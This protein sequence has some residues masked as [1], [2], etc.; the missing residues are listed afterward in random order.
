MRFISTIVFVSICI[1]MNLFSQDATV[2]PTEAQGQQVVGGTTLKTCINYSNVATKKPIC[3]PC[4][5]CTSENGSSASES[6]SNTI[7]G[8]D[9]GGVIASQSMIDFKF[10]HIH[11]A[12]DYNSLTALSGCAPCGADSSSKQNHL[13]SLVLGRYHRFRDITEQSSFGPGIFSNY[14]MT[15]TISPEGAGNRIR[16]FDPQYYYTIVYQD[17]L[18]G[19]TKDGVLF[20]NLRT[21]D[22]ARITN[23]AE[24]FDATNVLTSDLTLVKSVV[25]TSHSGRKFIFEVI[26]MAGGALA[27]RLTQI[28][29]RNG[30]SVVL[31]YKTWTQPEIDASHTLQ[32]QI[33]TITDA[34]GRV[35]SFNYEATQVSGQWVVSSIVLPNTQTIAY[36]YAGGF[37]TQIAHPDGTHSTFGY[38]TEP[39]SQCTVVS[40]NDASASSTHRRKKVYLTN[41]FSEQAWNGLPSV[42]NSA[43]LLVRMVVNGASEVSYFNLFNPAFPYEWINYIEGKVQYVYDGRQFKYYQDGWS[44]NSAGGWNA[45]SGTR[46]SS[47][48]EDNWGNIQNHFKNTPTWVRDDKGVTINLQ[49]NSRNFVTQKS[50]ADGSTE[51]F[52]YNDFMQI[53]RYKDRDNRV[54]KNT[55]DT[56][57]NLTKT[58]VGIL[59]TGGAD[60]NQAEYAT[61][62]KSYFSAGHA[63]QFLLESSTDANGN[64]TN[65]EYNANHFLV[66]VIEPAD[67]IGGMRAERVTAIDAY[68]RVA[69]QADA[70]GRTTSYFYDQKDRVNKIQYSDSS[71]EEMIYGSDADNNQNLI[72]ASKDRNGNLTQHEYDLH[73]RCTKVTVGAATMNAG[74]IS[75]VAD[76]TVK[77]ETTKSYKYGT[78]HHI[79]KLVHGGEQTDMLYDYKNREIQTTQYPN[80]TTTLVSKKLYVNNL[81]VQSTDAYN[82]KTFYAYRTSDANNIRVVRET[83][84]NAVSDH[85]T[86]ATLVRSM[87]ANASFVIRDEIKNNSGQTVQAIDPRGIVQASVYDSRQRQ[88][89]VVE[90]FGT[91]DAAKTTYQFD[92][93]SNLELVFHPRNFDN[94]DPEFGKCT[95]MMTYTG[96]NLLKTKTEGVNS[97]VSATCFYAYYLDRKEKTYTDFNGNIWTTIWHICCGRLEAKVDP[98]GNGTLYDVDYFG[99]VVHTSSGS[100]LP[101]DQS[102]YV[103]N[104]QPITA[105]NDVTTRFDERN[106]PTHTTVWLTPIGAITNKGRPALGNGQIPI[107]G[108]DGVPASQGLTTRYR[109]DDNLTDN[110]G[111]DAEYASKLV[112]LNIGL[113][114]DGSA[115]EVS[116]PEGEKTLMVKDGLGRTIKTVD[117]VSHEQQMVYDVVVGGLLETKQ[118]TAP[119]TLALTVKSQADGVGRV[120]KT[121]DQENQISLNEYDN[122]SNRTKSRDANNV[123]LDC[124]FDYRNRDISCAD[125]QGDTTTRIYNKSNQIISQTD[126]MG[127]TTTIIIDARNRQK[128]STNRIGSTITNIFDANNNLLSVTDGQGNATIYA[129]DQRNLQVQRTF[130]DSQ[131]ATDKVVF[132][133]DAIQRKITQLD[134]KGDL[135]SYQFD[136]ANRLLQRQYPDNLNDVFSYDAA[137]RMTQAVSNRYQSTVT[138]SYND[139]STIATEGLTTNGQNYQISHFFDTAKRNY[140]TTY[141]NGKANARAFTAR[142]QLSSVAYDG[143]LM[144]NFQYDQGMRETS[145]GL[146]NGLTQTISY[147]P[148]NTISQKSV[149]G[150]TNYSYTYNANKVKLS[151]TDGTMSSLSQIFSYDFENRLTSWSSN[152]TTLNETQSWNLSLEGAWLANTVNGVTENRTFNQTYETLTSDSNAMAH[153]RKGNLTNN[154]DGSL[155][156]WDFDNQL[157]FSSAGTPTVNSA[158]TYDALGRRVSKASGNTV[159]VFVHSNYQILTEYKSTNG[160][161]FTESQSFVYATYI[162]D[163]IALINANG[164]YFYHS[165]QQFSIGA[166]TD[167][168]GNLTERYGYNAYGKPVVISDSILVDN[169]Y[170]FTGRQ[171]DSETGLFYFRARYY[172]ASLGQFISRD[173]I[174]FVDGMSLYRGYF[175]SNSLDWEGLATQ[176]CC[177]KNGVKTNYDDTTHCCIDGV[178]TIKK[179]KGDCAITLYLSHGSTENLTPPPQKGVYGYVGCYTSQN[180]IGNDYPVING[181]VDLA[182]DA[183]RDI[184]KKAVEAAQKKAKKFEDICCEYVKVILSYQSRIKKDGK[185]VWPGMSQGQFTQALE[186]NEGSL[187]ELERGTG[188]TT[189]IKDA[190][191][192]AQRKAKTIEVKGS[193]VKNENY[194]SSCCKSAVSSGQ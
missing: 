62:Q 184:L 57:G 181:I 72:V 23:K 113:N 45:F 132:T 137:S 60:T 177:D 128:S 70:L 158:Y 171:L 116:N 88:I 1:S 65:Y 55:Y 165:N 46:E 136:M 91:A 98:L 25:I 172:D 29:D 53:T 71:T 10:N 119:S 160:G 12:F 64:I 52:A 75:P 41:N 97:S 155:Y 169:L 141:P 40:Y 22:Q 19:D 35:M 82:R 121:I 9:V 183:G 194:N 123:G 111:L 134:Q 130:A 14:D 5:T 105:L 37:L 125:T 13:P 50:Y 112:G 89:E 190:L 36:S 115:V 156:T 11:F 76:T 129:Y 104:N 189:G 150:I 173:P 185:V 58:E 102:S 187:V 17:G 101:L 38:T 56:Q 33:A 175:A 90:A 20:E 6:D 51:Q 148:D 135:I 74:V 73:G 109:Y 149:A 138:R 67:D 139:D 7:T 179:V 117:A 83:V 61:Y 77:L 68:G 126:A 107:A 145:R 28:K 39:V 34:F 191:T 31:T 3:E 85:I 133:Y 84:P 47:F 15:L 144:A 110:V 108:E 176:E 157:A 140:Q 24:M 99:N 186:F 178:I 87:V 48:W 174:G 66:K 153:D 142:N 100:G 120:Q 95:T 63:Q 124:I 154:K 146:G 127:N 164:S 170:F 4:G 167:S 182:S 180:N 192:V 42:Y 162:D 80:T 8:Y 166:I 30:Y 81:M 78:N 43:S 168:N 96:R 49:Y 103:C 106:R 114:A 16:F 193:P 27:G 18:F 152:G 159:T 21:Y 92:D 69:T 2:R 161:A 54:T 79:Y 151:E 94:T 131:D 93:N 32:Y 118:I 147:R 163:P 122:N 86:A 59:F 143:N 44:F 188:E 26:T